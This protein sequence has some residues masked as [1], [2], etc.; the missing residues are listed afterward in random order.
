MCVSEFQRVYDCLDVSI[1]ERGE[2]YYQ[3][4]MTDVVKE[5]EKEGR[6]GHTFCNIL[7]HFNV[8]CGSQ[9]VLLYNVLVVPSYG[10]TTRGQYCLIDILFFWVL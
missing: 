8:F 5:F 7:I 10:L 9:F 2:S 3:D 4:M 6:C 1:I